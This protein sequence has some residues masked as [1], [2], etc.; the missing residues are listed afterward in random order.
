MI[1]IIPQM[2]TYFYQKPLTVYQKPA[3]YS[4]ISN[5]CSEFI[6][7]SKRNVSVILKH[8]IAIHAWKIK[9]FYLIMQCG[10]N[11]YEVGFYHS[12]QQNYSSTCGNCILQFVSR[13][14]FKDF[15][16]FISLL[17]S[18]G[19]ISLTRKAYSRILN[20]YWKVILKW[21]S[22]LLHFSFIYVRT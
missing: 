6:N 18:S 10:K 1:C 13:K 15:S 21:S 14:I 4:Y 20:I 9:I 17:F 22:I 16:W 2:S 12:Q 8:S 5:L 3:E 7:K 19:N 11:I